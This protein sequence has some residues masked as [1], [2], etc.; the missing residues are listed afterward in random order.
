MGRTSIYSLGK[1]L[2]VSPATVS[3]A[4]SMHP[5]ISA[6]I[7]EKVRKAAERHSFKP[8]FVSGRPTAVY[9]LVQQ[10][11]GHPL[12]FDNFLARSL[13]GIA[14]Y[15][16][17]EGLEMGI[18]SSDVEKL[19]E[20]D[21]VRELS[22]RGAS[23]AVV[24]RSSGQSAYLKQLES[25][26]FPHFRLFN[27]TDKSSGC[28]FDID[29]RSL[30]EEAAAHLLALGHRRIGFIIDDAPFP[31]HK[32]RLQG[33]KDALAKAGIPYDAKLVFSGSSL[34]GGLE[35]GRLGVE[36]LL[37]ENP[38]MT[39]VFAVSEPMAKGVLG[40]L[41]Q[42]GIPAPERISV[43]AF[44]DFPE[45]A[46]LCPPLTT[47][48]VPYKRIGYEGARQA[49]RLFKGLPPQI[50][51]GLGGSLIVRASTGPAPKLKRRKP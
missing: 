21:V 3:R 11:K 30:A 7:R 37:A 51:E 2:G 28:S 5:S 20:C 6:E 9:A 34:G 40:W 12:D 27:A 10:L 16:R 38:D 19:N 42:K 8:R 48:Q 32:A 33:C 13:E 41:W 35:I 43:V 39:A 47:V 24:L 15:C 44:D 29:N 17:D 50:P 1:E 18:F 14:E 45:T 22:K 4:L 23:A 26:K 31:A 46:W 25:Q 36:A 49:H